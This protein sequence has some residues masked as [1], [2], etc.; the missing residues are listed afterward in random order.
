MNASQLSEGVLAQK[1]EE[2]S[3]LMGAY[4]AICARGK[5][6]PRD[7]MTWLL[8]QLEEGS[9]AQNH[10]FYIDG[11]PDFTRQHFAILECLIRLSPN[12]TISINCDVPDSRMLAFEKA[13]ETA[14]QILRC[15]KRAGVEISVET[16]PERSDGLLPLRANLFQG[17]I[18]EGVPCA[19][20]NVVR[21]ASVWQE[22]LAAGQYVR[23]LVI[24]GYRYRDVSVVVTDM[25][26]YQ[27][28]LE[29]VFARLHIPL[30][31]SGTED[32]LQKNVICTVLTALEAAVSGYDRKSVLEYLR[33][34]L[35]PLDQDTC[36][37]IENYS[38]VWNIRGKQWLA[39]WTFHP[40]GLSGVWDEVSQKQLR[41]LNT[42]RLD[43]VAPLE[44]LRRKLQDASALR[45]QILALY[46]FLEEIGLEQRLE[47]LSEEYRKEG[48]ERNVQILGQLWEIL[49]SALEQMY[50]VLGDTQ[51]ETEHFER[52]LSLLLSQYNVGTIP[53]V[54]DAVQMGTVSA[55]R[56]HITKHLLVLGAEEGK[57][58]GYSGSAGLLT[59]QERVALRAL[60]V[61]LTGG[62]MEGIQSEFAEIYGV[63]SCAE[64][65]VQVYCSSQQPSFLFRRLENLAGGSVQADT[66]MEFSTAEPSEAA[67]WL[68]VRNARQEASRLGLT[69]Y[70]E[71]VRRR[72]SHSLGTV[73]PQSIR[74]LYGRNLNLSASQ[75]DTQ[76]ECR[77]QYFLKYGLRARERR[78]AALDP[79]EFGTYI[80][81][82]LENT[83]RCVRDLG[84]F[85]CVDLERTL[86]IA[87]DYSDRYAQEHFGPL[88]SQRAQFLFRRNLRELDMVVEE[89]WTEL[90]ASEFSPRDFEVNFGSEDGLPAIPIPND[91]IGAILRG[92][93]D[94]VDIWNNG[95]AS[96]YRVVDYKTGKKDFDYCDVFNGVG[97]Q[98]LL[99]LFALKHS[100]SDLFENTPI[101]AGVQYFPARAPYL[102]MDGK[103]ETAEAENE[104][105]DKWKRKGLL[106]NDEAVLHAMEPGENPNRSFKIKKDGS[107]QGDLADREQLKQLELYIFRVLKKLVEDIAAGNVEPNPY[108]RGTSHDAC[109][110]C[111]YGSVCHKEEVPGRRNYK[112]MT[113]QRFWEEIGKEL[114][115]DA[116]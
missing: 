31:Q 93:V 77:L 12:V 20:L 59:D 11:F 50:D 97:L 6:D 40:D 116:E 14:A 19:S 16:V 51:W 28:V 65:T 76:A 74:G 115:A 37:L 114:E 111:P 38:V 103:P 1:L 109:R 106:L 113:A 107:I 72:A 98:M 3:L 67:A 89:L 56:C 41:I 108:C 10:V 94:R 66:S 105:L 101:P 36:D 13:G 39:E 2:L 104:R 82:V 25:T 26:T 92:F 53:P 85:H 75:I 42:A 58:P 63:F 60:G 27:P 29:Q 15:A 81:A 64:E 80:H 102:S 44:H 78:E 17:H 18:Q 79:A 57:L 110:F 54:L 8:E 33:S 88:A 5:R 68:A 61:P 100:G 34:A 24:Q 30:Y 32:I 83:A 43:A 22:C 7:Q 52:L 4:D 23:Q 35:S 49:M 73:S 21:T 99:Y 46:T 84:G 71:D 70:F 62:A 55:M 90:S 96:Y 95:A 47:E 69:Q 87:H 86:S 45:D 48:D 91:R 9:Y 112:M